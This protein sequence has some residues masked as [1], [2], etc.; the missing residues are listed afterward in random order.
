MGWES[1]DEDGSQE[2]V[3]GVKKWWLESGGA[4]RESGGGGGSQKVVVGVRRCRSGVRR[5]GGI[6]SWIWDQEVEAVVRRWW[7][8]SIAGSGSQKVE[9]VVRRW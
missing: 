3:V 1:G 2:V 6:K 4:G 8:E 9:A 7:W 5:C